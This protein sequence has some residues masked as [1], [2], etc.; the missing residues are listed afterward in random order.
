[1]EKLEIGAHLFFLGAVVAIVGLGAFWS[2]KLAYQVLN[3]VA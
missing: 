3:L 1:M 2:V